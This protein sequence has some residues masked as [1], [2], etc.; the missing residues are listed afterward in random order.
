M[1]FL[2]AFAYFNGIEIHNISTAPV[3]EKTSSSATDHQ[4][5]SENFSMEILNNL[6]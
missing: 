1:S 3:K 2:K 5:V 6:N 4:N